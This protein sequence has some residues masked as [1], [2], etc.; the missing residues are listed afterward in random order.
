MMADTNTNTPLASFMASC[1][2]ADLSIRSDNAITHCASPS[3][4]IQQAKYCRWNS[5]PNLHSPM[6]K[7]SS[8][9]KNRKFNK[10]VPHSPKP[11][12]AQQDITPKAPRRTSAPDL[13]TFMRPLVS[14]TTPCS[15]PKMPRRSLDL[16][17]KLYDSTI[18]LAGEINRELDA[19]Y[20][21]PSV[22]Y[23]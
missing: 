3:P 4:S 15:P 1:Q 23:Q 10:C 18:T 19:M 9:R 12:K 22:L 17:E 11:N 20:H 14:P 8:R 16:E 13:K 7:K 2:L 6:K 5:M 21:L